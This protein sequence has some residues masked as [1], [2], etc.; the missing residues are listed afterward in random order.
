M[1]KFQYKRR[2]A[3]NVKKRMNQSATN[4]DG[5]INDDVDMYKVKDGDNLV[6]FLPPTFE[7]LNGAD[8]EHYGLDVF[9][10]YDVGTDG[11]SFLCL[12]Q[13]FNEPCPICQARLEMEAEG[14]KEEADKLKAR[15]RVLIY[16]IDRDNEDAGPLVWSAPWTV[17]KDVSMRSYD[18]RSGEVYYPD[19][20]EDGFDIEF[21]REGKGRTTK[22]VGVQLAR[23]SSA[24][25]RD[26]DEMDE[27]LDKIAGNPLHKILI[28]PDAER[29]EKAFNAG[30]GM[31]GG[32]EDEDEKEEK[33]SRSSRRNKDEDED[34]KEEKKS[35]RSRRDE[36]D[37]ED[38]KEEKPSR[39]SRRNKDEDEDEKEEKPSRSSRRNK[40]EDEDEKEEKKSAKSNEVKEIDDL[41]YD[42]VSEMDRDDLEA[43]VEEAKLDIPDVEDLDDNELVAEV[44]AELG[45]KKPRR[46]NSAVRSRLSEMNEAS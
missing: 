33:P 18:K 15:K 29:M 10:H 40:D 4:R 9:V 31:S 14:L 37:D 19:D 23:K 39:S 21:A 34:E 41:E 44:C 8:A 30:M 42:D 32:K 5:F 26:E 35:R 43:I 1:A 38:E 45:L 46:R 6:R 28:K 3:D 7:N 24:L 13:N 16:V 12:E 17:D 25:S 11:S 2:N 22:Y 36:K 20:P 27:W